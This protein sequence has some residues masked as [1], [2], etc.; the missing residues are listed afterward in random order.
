LEARLGVGDVLERLLQAAAGLVEQPAVIAAAEPAVFHEAV[1]HVGPTVWAM[2]VD[3]PVAAALVLVEGEVLAHEPHGLDRGVVH[4]GD[5][6]D[7]HPV[8]PH[9]LAHERAGPDR[10]ESP[11]LLFSQHGVLLLSVMCAA[12][13]PWCRVSTATMT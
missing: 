11:V 3:E 10:R 9:Q 13:G 12:V 5:G 2:P 8:A 6:R 7:G 1:A 4:L